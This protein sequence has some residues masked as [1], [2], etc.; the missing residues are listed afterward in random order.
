MKRAALAAMAAMA[1]GA[2]AAKEPVKLT[3]EAVNAEAA[4]EGPAL[5]GAAVSPDGALVTLLRGRA[6]DS[7]Q[8]DL[9]AYDI[10]TG[11]AR[12]LVSSTD[13][14]GEEEALSEE[15]KNRRERQRIFENGIVAYDWD[16]AGRQILF[17]LGGDVFVYDLASGAARRITETEAFETDPKFSPKGRYVSYVRDDDLYVYDLALGRETRA[18]SGANGVLRNAVA[19][20]V[21]QEE[22]DRDTGYWWSP[23]EAR[24]AFTEIDESPVRIAE[25]VDINADGVVTIRQRYPFA[26]TANVRIRLGVARPGGGRPVWIDLGP[27]PDIY[28]ARVHWSEDSSRL[29]VERL[30]RDQKRLDLIEADPATG[31]TRLVFAEER[32]TW[33]NLNNDFRALKAGGFVW[34]SERS[35]RQQLY[36]YAADGTLV[37]AISPADT[38]V[39]ALDCVDEA[40]GVVYFEGWRDSA[41]ERHLFA[42]PLAGGEARQLTSEPGFHSADY[43]K[44]CATSIRRFS[45]DRQPP[46]S[47][48][49]GADGAFRFWINE[50]RVEGDHPYAPYLAS[51]LDWT[52]GQIPAADGTML[53][54]KL[55]KPAGLRRGEKRP[56]I[57]LVYGGPHAQRV[58]NAWEGGF[59]Q[60]LADE[61]YVVFRLDNRG[62]AN[63]GTAF[64]DHLHRN[65]GVVEVEDQAAGARHLAALPFVDPARIGVYGWSYGGYMTLRMLTATPD[66]YRSGVAGAPVTDWALYD[67]AYT[68][69]YM[70]KPEEEQDAYA[71]GS[72]FADL[73]A[74]KGELLVIHGMA[75]DNVVFQNSVKL[76]DA[77]QKRGVSFEMMTYPGEKHG[78]RDT[79]NKIHRDRLI[80][81]FFERTLKRR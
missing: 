66:L 33:I 42:V 9:W 3:P 50:N 4:L 20:F 62:A 15:E 79:A 39:T 77:L 14:A 53:D 24:I 35:G 47:S 28:L 49:H 41:V 32:A 65:M 36:R 59:A 19:E 8:L 48:V 17:P 18:T 52:Y 68:E 38:L 40:N 12:L 46:R 76:F 10:A 57:V 13:L 6:E 1:A 25:R 75:D 7:R 74:L 30:T 69:R 64:E 61:G 58:S 72:A 71:R 31:R 2:T 44:N 5:R 37:G 21:A 78:F 26:G 81:D 60:M 67:T 16:D 43:A 63:R 22:L 73:D 51:H 54:Y 45:S 23:D 56:A 27:D 34:G 70:G 29:Y 55:L 11:A 80:L